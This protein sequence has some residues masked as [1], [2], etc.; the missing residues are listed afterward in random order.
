ME[1]MSKLQ[2]LSLVPV[3]VPWPNPGVSH[4]CY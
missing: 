3:P 1:I 2:Q 4:Y